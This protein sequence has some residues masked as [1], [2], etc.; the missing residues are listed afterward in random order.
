MTDAAPVNQS[1]GGGNQVPYPTGLRKSDRPLPVQRIQTLRL[2]TQ[3]RPEGP[4]NVLVNP[5]LP[6][7]EIAPLPHTKPRNEVPDGEHYTG[8]YP[9]PGV[10]ACGPE[11][12]HGSQHASVSADCRDAERD[13]GFPGSNPPGDRCRGNRNTE[14][15][16]ATE[17]QLYA[18]CGLAFRRLTQRKINHQRPCLSLGV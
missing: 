11:R 2:R 16:I 5:D 7:E 18:L 10:L 9:F 17:D 13:T 8:G 12:D 14:T 1:N 15:L 4:P 3:T 6:T